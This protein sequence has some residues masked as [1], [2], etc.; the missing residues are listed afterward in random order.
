MDRNHQDQIAKFICYAI[1]CLI[2]YYI[3]MALLPYVIAFFAI[4]GAGY[5]FHEYQKNNRR[6]H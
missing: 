3:L 1:G 6:R 2:A 4:L 5:V